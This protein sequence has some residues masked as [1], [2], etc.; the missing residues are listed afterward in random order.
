MK[1]A[2]LTRSRQAGREWQAGVWTDLLL[3]RADDAL[4]EG[5][6]PF[7]KKARRVARRQY[8]EEEAFVAGAKAMWV[9]DQRSW[10]RDR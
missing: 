1:P 3:E 7:E 9:A 5:P 2:S 4:L 10:R 8:F 6:W